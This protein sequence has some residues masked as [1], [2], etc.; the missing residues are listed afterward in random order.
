VILDVGKLQGRHWITTGT[1]GLPS[2]RLLSDDLKQALGDFLPA[3]LTL[4][5]A[6]AVRT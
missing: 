6:R 4:V 1:L 5:E 2:H 3:H